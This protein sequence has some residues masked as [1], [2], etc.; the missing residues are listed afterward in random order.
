LQNHPVWDERG[1]EGTTARIR[2]KQKA[3]DL[4]A[5]AAQITDDRFAA[6]PPVDVAWPGRRA[7]REMR[8]DRN[9]DRLLHPSA[10]T[11]AS[12]DTALS[13]VA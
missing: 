2:E 10:I 7:Y 11:S 6:L 9:T 5:M 3:G 12:S 1:F 8:S 4:K 13:R